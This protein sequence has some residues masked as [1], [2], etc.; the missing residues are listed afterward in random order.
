MSEGLAVPM[1]WLEWDSKLRPTAEPPRHIT[2]TVLF[3]LPAGDT[4]RSGF[5]LPPKFGPLISVL[6]RPEN[7]SV[8]SAPRTTGPAARS[9][10]IGSHRAQQ[11]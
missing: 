8:A 7:L 2:V 9:G 6:S 10:V 3:L 5:V 4:E 11:R 1:W